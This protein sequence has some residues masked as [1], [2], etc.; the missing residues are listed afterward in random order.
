[1]PK[2][3]SA[4]QQEDFLNAYVATRGNIQQSCA[5]V[6]IDRRTFYNWKKDPI[7]L[8]KLVAFVEQSE[9][10]IV[11]DIT[12]ALYNDFMWEAQIRS[13]IQA[14]DSKLKK[15]MKDEAFHSLGFK[16]LSLTKKGKELL[17]IVQPKP[18]IEKNDALIE[19][20]K[21][22]TDKIAPLAES[23]GE[24]DPTAETADESEAD[25]DFDIDDF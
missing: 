18:P 7:F 23:V 21:N 22:F 16:L 10:K 12:L 14:G 3:T 2:T 9:D 17:G 19:A 25:D 5:R 15:G 8:E 24:F 13:K 4:Q 1:M 6:G 11:D 20:F